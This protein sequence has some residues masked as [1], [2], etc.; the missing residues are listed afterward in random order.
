MLKM[1]IQGELRVPKIDLSKHCENIGRK[2][3][4]PDIIDGIHAGMSIKGGKLPQPLPRTFKRSQNKRVLDDTGELLD[5]FVYRP[6]GKTQ[7]I[8]TISTGRIKIAGYLQNKGI[9]SSKGLRK[10]IFFGIS[11]DASKAGM[12]YMRQQIKELTRANRA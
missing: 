1:T 6:K 11:K 12:D 2:I 4:I 9:R 7:G 8:I 3:I 5:S 10:Y